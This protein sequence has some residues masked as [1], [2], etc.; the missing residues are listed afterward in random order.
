MTGVMWRAALRLY[1]GGVDSLGQPTQSSGGRPQLRLSQLVDRIERAARAGAMA[2]NISLGLD[3]D[4]IVAPGYQPHTSADSMHVRSVVRRLVPT[5]RALEQAGHRPLLILSAGNNGLNDAF[6]NG[7][8][9]ILDSLPGRALVVAAA[10]S[11]RTQHGNLAGFSNHGRLV[12][13]AAPGQGVRTLR[14]GQIVAL[15]GTS[16]AAPRVTGIAGLLLSS[17]PNLT[18]EQLRELILQ[19]AIDGGRTAG[20]LPLANAYWSLRRGAEI[21]GTPLCGNRI[22][23]ADGHVRARRGGTVENLFSFAAEGAF[24][25]AFHGG[26]RLRIFDFDQFTDRTFAFESGK[27]IERPDSLL[28][29]R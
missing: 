18:R 28:H 25:N 22:W 17:T 27:W 4:S 2:I 11:A 24:M 20:G 10:D 3:W 16:L 19:G 5:L 9:A 14:G 7:F 8:P 29:Q 21:V 12:D 15:N 23:L 6:W 26:R 1:E 13:L